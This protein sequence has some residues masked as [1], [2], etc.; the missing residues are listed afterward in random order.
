M[1]YLVL[2]I[3]N[4]VVNCLEPTF[5]NYE[6]ILYSFDIDNA[7]NIIGPD[8]NYIY[9]LLSQQRNVISQ[10]INTNENQY[11]IKKK[12]FDAATKAEGFYEFI[13][14]YPKLDDPINRNAA[15]KVKNEYLMSILNGEAADDPLAKFILNSRCS[16]YSLSDDT[17]KEKDEDTNSPPNND[18]GE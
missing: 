10:E 6:P 3:K 9:N 16:H 13:E 11:N 7:G 12:N 15:N 5:K 18:G 17:K 14:S 2:Y 4:I 8:I 1:I